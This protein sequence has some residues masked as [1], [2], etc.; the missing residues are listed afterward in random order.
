M[1]VEIDSCKW[2]ET[3]SGNILKEIKDVSL[4]EHQDDGTE[5]IIDISISPDALVD[6]TAGN[7]IPADVIYLDE[8]SGISSFG[9]PGAQS[10][11]R[12]CGLILERVIS[13]LKEVQAQSLATRIK[14]SL[15]SVSWKPTLL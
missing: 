15:I 14:R 1:L 10:L 7:Q 6:K 8:H 2:N 12:W 3:V 13:G 11:I 9:Q 5:S 4:E